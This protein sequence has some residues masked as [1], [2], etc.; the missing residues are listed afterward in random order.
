MD[1]S[2]YG[3]QHA[4]RPLTHQLR[5]S[6]SIGTKLTEGMIG[7]LHRQRRTGRCRLDHSKFDR[8]GRVLVPEVGKHPV[9]LRQGKRPGQH[10]HDRR[11]LL[12]P[13]AKHK[14]WIA[15]NAKTELIQIGRELVRV[16]VPGVSQEIR[17]HVIDRIFDAL[18]QQA[19]QFLNR[20]V[21][22]FSSPLARPRR[23]Q[24]HHDG[25]DTH[26]AQISDGLSLLIQSKWTELHHLPLKD[27][28]VLRQQRN[29]RLRGSHR[30]RRD[31]EFHEWLLSVRTGGIKTEGTQAF[32]QHSCF[33]T[34]SI[35]APSSGRS[36]HRDTSTGI[37]A[38]PPASASIRCW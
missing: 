26:P 29:P 30:I 36:G 33:G 1:A 10:L 17:R 8:T 14:S 16:A 38:S 23:L 6:P 31:A 32:A 20:L 3:R 28:A 12:H 27:R 15:G 35:P 11:G 21:P 34:A 24:I 13:A 2:R 18:V 19:A 37:T 4:L 22:G 25:P 9:N 7:K 5:A